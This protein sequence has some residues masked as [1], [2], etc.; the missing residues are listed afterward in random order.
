MDRPME[1]PLEPPL[2]VP[3][4]GSVLR[5]LP[6]YPSAP[7]VEPSGYPSFATGGHPSFDTVPPAPEPS[8]WFSSAR[9]HSSNGQ[10]PADLPPVAA[11][12]TGEE[13]L[14]IFASV[15]EESGWFSKP[16][17]TAD[18][19]DTAWTTPSDQAW[20]AADATAEPAN[21]GTTSSGLPKRTPRANLVPGTASPQPPPPVP[22]PPVSPDRLRS[23][24]ASYQQGMRKG[25]A[26]LDEEDS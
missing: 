9:P 8:S 4:P 17:P 19:R 24:L 1:P 14:P 6:S 5:P 2:D 15:E 22:G 16:A 26:E 7:P 18:H 12:P 10:S 21:G 20:Q 11:P 13:Y 25:R 3:R 23:R